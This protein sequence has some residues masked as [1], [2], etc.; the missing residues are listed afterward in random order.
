MSAFGNRLLAAVAGFVVGAAFAG[1]AAFVAPVFA[2]EV[3]AGEV[4]TGEVFAGAAFAGVFV[5]EVFVTEVFA[6]AAFVA[7]FATA[8][9][10]AAFA[11]G[12]VLA[13]FA[14]VPAVAALAPALPCPSAA[15]GFETAFADAFTGAFDAFATRS[16][17]AIPVRPFWSPMP[18][19]PPN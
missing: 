19:P 5:A 9:A 12:A 10:V 14:R 13:D 11:A 1:D 6:G 8:L 16:S 17:L 15:A 4:F 2:G 18:R 7:G 3:F